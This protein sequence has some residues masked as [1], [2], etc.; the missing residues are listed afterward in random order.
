[1]SS[2]KLIL[3]LLLF[4]IDCSNH[5]PAVHGPT[6]IQSDCTQPAKQMN[7]VIETTYP[8]S[9]ILLTITSPT[10]VDF[11]TFGFPTA[12]LIV[13]PDT[14]GTVGSNTRNCHLD[15]TFEDS[16]YDNLEYLYSCFENGQLVCTMVVHQ[17][18]KQ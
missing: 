9:A 10:E 4:T 18:T 16:H 12:T 15:Y 7:V 2:K 1:M 5:P 3:V 6:Y 14:I 8:T 13:Q 11:T 17:G